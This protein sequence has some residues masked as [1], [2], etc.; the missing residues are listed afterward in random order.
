MMNDGQGRPVLID[1]DPGIDDALAIFMAL[2]T[3]ELFVTGITTCVGNVPVEHTTRNAMQIVE[4]AQCHVEVA[5]GAADPLF[6]KR[7]TAES[8]H[9]SNGIGDIFLPEPSASLSDKKPHELIYE[10]AL[11]YQGELELIATGPLTNVANTI[12]IHP[13][14]TS[15]IKRIWI[16]GGAAGSGNRNPA[17]EFNIFADAHGAS[18]VFKSGI[19]ITMCG[20]DVTNKALIYE[21]DIN[22]L[23]R[24]GNSVSTQSALM[25]RWYLEFYR[26]FGF[27]GVAM[28]DPLTVA[29]AIDP[30][31]VR[32]EHLHVEVETEGEFTLGKTVVDIYGVRVKKPN[33]DVALELDN[34]RFVALFENLMKRYNP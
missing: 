34:D 23:A 11:F 33:A 14:I 3:D 13:Q 19:P 8:V 12:L 17:A 30:S 7:E 31:I 6:S 32:T 5:K 9:G 29:V 4:L 10:K 16:M 21:E 27:E 1:C 28:H 22:K 25:L 20:L 26:S 15:L 24:L 18:I 2:A